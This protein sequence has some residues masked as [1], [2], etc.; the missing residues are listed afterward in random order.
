MDYILVALVG[1]VIGVVS[2]MVAARIDAAE[3]ERIWRIVCADA[4]RW[5][6]L[7]DALRG[8]GWQ[9]ITPQTILNVLPERL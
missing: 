7:E 3:E 5:R 6:M 2:V 4:D 8:R 9:H 1:F